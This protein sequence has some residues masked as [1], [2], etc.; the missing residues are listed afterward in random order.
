MPDS[1]E[2][3]HSW[4]D[5]EDEAAAHS[6]AH[7]AS[8]QSRQLATVFHGEYCQIMPVFLCGDP[9]PQVLVVP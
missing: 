9:K 2:K 8:L 5:L 6:A 7:A 3:S 1:A 4:R